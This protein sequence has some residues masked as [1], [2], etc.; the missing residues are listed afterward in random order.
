MAELTG[1]SFTID[2][3]LDLPA[4]GFSVEVPGVAPFLAASDDDTVALSAGLI[5]PATG[6]PYTVGQVSGPVDEYRL[7]VS[8]D[9]MVC[10]LR[11][12]DSMAEL[13][14]RKFQ[15]RYLRM[16]PTT[17]EAAAMDGRLFAGASDPILWTV[18]E[19]RASD[20]AREVVESCGL[21]LAWE[22]RD[23]TLQED[24]DA[25][26]R[27]I[28]ILKQLVAPWCQ[29]EPYR[30]DV[31]VQATTVFCRPRSSAPVADYTYT[32]ADARIKSLTV[33]RRQLPTIG[34][35][36]LLG[37]IEGKGLTLVNGIPTPS[38]VE[39]TT[40]S[41]TRDSGDR[42][43]SRVV[44]TTTYQMPE[45]VVLRSKEQLYAWQAND[46]ST[47]GGSLD[48]RKEESRWNEWEEIKYD[49]T[50]PRSHPRQ[51]G[52]FTTTKSNRLNGA[53]IPS[54][55]VAEETI[56][57]SYDDEDYLDMTTT[58]KRELRKRPTQYLPNGTIIPESYELVPSERITRVLKEV[59]NLATEE[60]TTVEK[61]SNAWF[62]SKIDTVKSAGLRPG[63]PRPG[64]SIVIGGG[65]TGPAE[66]IRLEE[67]ISA[68]ADAQDLTFSCPH[69]E[70]A[71]LDYIWAAIAAAS[72][73]W[74]YE[75]QM[76]YLAMPWIRK[77][78]VILLTSLVDHTGAPV[79][80]Q[81]ALITA[82]TLRYDEGGNNPE[83]VSRLTATYWSAS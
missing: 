20:I 30:V 83:M 31:F 74:Q 69:L 72:G 41:E 73:A 55:V 51:L 9:R 67:I 53:V 76:E 14:G 18:G 43:I 16:Q 24:F 49:Q 35:L 80:L 33:S 6:I 61:W 78:N 12:R 15:K 40:T 47:Q 10:S 59:E 39:E 11:G 54:Q 64:R 62:V 1:K 2:S 3:S 50:G 60:T 56:R 23:Y 8:P 28:D 68:D 29:A 65:P 81:P 70:Q 48:L 34:K 17:A 27:C 19:F 22:C 4:D 7:D 32:I 45:K 57:H 13:I 66:P 36:T 38:E 37:R 5:D 25:S 71:D 26:G 77:G 82:Q 52:S 42:V 46:Q 44:R 21:T 63:G 58:T 79:P 75:L